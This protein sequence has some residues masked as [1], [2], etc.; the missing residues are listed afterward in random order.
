MRAKV[1]KEDKVRPTRTFLIET[2]P[3]RPGSNLRNNNRDS[4]LPTRSTLVAAA[5]WSPTPMTDDDMLHDP[6]GRG[7]TTSMFV[8]HRFL[9]V[10]GQNVTP[11][12][13][14]P[15]MHPNHHYHLTQS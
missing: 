8:W 15:S 4:H 14:Q 12:L 7:M 6:A 13:A 5:V 1:D 3:C 10:P 11:P 2:E 9:S